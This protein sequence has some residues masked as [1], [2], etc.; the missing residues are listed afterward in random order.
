MEI[1]QERQKTIW[2]TTDD[3]K[4]YRCDTCGKG[5]INIQRLSEHLNVHT[6]D[7]G[8]ENLEHGIEINVETIEY[9]D[10]G[11]ISGNSNIKLSEQFITSII[12][13]VDELCEKIKTGDPDTKRTE[14]SQDD[15]YNL[16][17]P[18]DFS[19]L[20]FLWSGPSV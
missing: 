7:S 10:D 13:Q 17:V 8:E 3:Q 19:E 12:K 18:S 16:G 5:F 1:S 6:G 4:K 11:Q 2:D 15:P 14:Q 20:D 9:Q